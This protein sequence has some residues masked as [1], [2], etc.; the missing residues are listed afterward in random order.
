[1]RTRPPGEDIGRP[2][3]AWDA[4]LD[5]IT[6]ILGGNDASSFDIDAS[7]GQLITKA[8]LD[9]ETMSSYRVTVRVHDGKSSSGSEYNGIDAYK[10]VTIS[11]TNL[12]EAGE[13]SLSSTQPH[14]G[15]PL[16]AEV[17]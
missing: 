11:L 1:M 9:Y 3:S 4:Q 6:Y 12:D 5:T 15:T 2:V 16:E 8:P 7:S 10:D 17:T 13:L 14:V